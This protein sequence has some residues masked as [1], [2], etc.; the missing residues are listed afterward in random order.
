MSSKEPTDYSIMKSAI[1]KDFKPTPE[2]IKKINKYF[3]I[4]YISGD[5]RYIHIANILNSLPNIP[6]EAQYELIRCSSLDKVKYTN[7]RKKKFSRKQIKTI[8]TYYN[9]SDK[10]AKEYL[11][12][13][14]EEEY[15]KISSILESKNPNID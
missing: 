14:P 4:R 10:V 1:T 6:I 7:F 5:L 15:L 3:L 9:V 2:Q 13:L 11:E 8:K 12:I